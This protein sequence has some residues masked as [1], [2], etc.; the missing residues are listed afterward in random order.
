MNFEYTDIEVAKYYNLH[1]GKFYFSAGWTRFFRS[2]FSDTA[3]FIE[4]GRAHV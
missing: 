3:F 2:R 4:I 1:R